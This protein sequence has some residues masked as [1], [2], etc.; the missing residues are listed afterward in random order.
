MATMPMDNTPTPRG[1]GK[2]PVSAHPA[3]PAVVALW[4][5]ALLGIG[6]LILP[7]HLYETILTATGISGIIS[8]AA[9]PL[10]FTARALIALVATVCGAGLGLY[11]AR[12][13]SG[14]SGSIGLFRREDTSS[15]TFNAAEEI[16]EDGIAEEIAE[17]ED[18]LPPMRE[19]IIP[20]GRRRALAM[21]EDD[22]PSELL[23]A[24]PL[25]GEQTGLWGGLGGAVMQADD[26]LELFEEVE[27]EAY[28]DLPMQD[29]ATPRQEFM[30]DAKPRETAIAGA[31]ATPLDLVSI[32]EEPALAEPLPFSPPSLTRKDAQPFDAPQAIPGPGFLNPASPR[33]F[34]SP[35]AAMP[36][37]QTEA[38]DD[39]SVP[40]S[41]PD[42]CPIFSEDTVS[43]KPFTQDTAHADP[44]AAK[45]FDAPASSLAEGAQ[46]E[47]GA[48]LVQLVQK[49]GSTLEKHREWSAQ[50]AAQGFAV[51]AVTP[52]PHA[53]AHSDSPGEAMLAEEFDPAAPD[54]AAEAM[55]AYFGKSAA[56]VVNS[57]AAETEES[58][59]DLRPFAAPKQV[60]QSVEDAAAADD[61]LHPAA[62]APVAGEAYAPFTGFAAKAN[63]SFAEEFE[64]EAEV[65]SLAA[66]F[67]LPIAAKPAPAPVAI[68][69]VESEPLAFS[70]RPAFD[71]PPPS[72]VPAARAESNRDADYTAV[73]AHNPFKANAEDFVRIN[74]PEPDTAEPA[75]VFPNQQRRAGS[76]GLTQPPA[77]GEHTGGA[78]AAP[79][80][81]AAASNDDNERAL[82]EAL[83]N[84]QRM[85]K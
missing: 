71:M 84:L 2:P 24:A 1:R 76:L 74:E 75:V 27:P 60:F 85:G 23:N 52:A 82:R 16:A 83:M 38:P 43:D 55:A 18:D 20:A 22:G 29:F 54:E 65:A 8:A 19:S 45:P 66:S 13:M 3:F 41:S 77:A 50:R 15:R 10:G 5:A 28:A 31:D 58:A 59:E 68:E 42:T 7:V 61:Q 17:E 35:K 39:S 48:G 46:G 69:P 36:T 12:R 80:P 34:E 26:A 67:Q 44:S 37:I 79:A 32:A 72:V 56:S 73:A 6:S 9:P 70:P 4:F 78:F 57:V 30:P 53:D 21:A 11:A 25:P 49:L 33:L 64:E 62:P 14:K 47:G 63:E 81:N 40:D 51:K